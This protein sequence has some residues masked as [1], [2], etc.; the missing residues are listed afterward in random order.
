MHRSKAVTSSEKHK[1]IDL[2]KAMLP[3]VGF[4]RVYA[5]KNNVNETNTVSRLKSIIKRDNINKSFIDELVKAYEYLMFL[6]FR[7]QTAKILSSENPDNSLRIDELTN[8]EKA[9]LK[10]VLVEIAEIYTQLSFDFEGTM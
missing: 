5:L 9:T 10:A 2:K 4:A 8:I 7:L 3:V 6:R 1:T